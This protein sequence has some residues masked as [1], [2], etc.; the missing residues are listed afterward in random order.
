MPHATVALSV[1][2]AVSRFGG[3]R[4]LVLGDLMLDRYLRGKAER[5]SP[6]APVPVVKVETE[7]L[8]LGGAANVATNLAALGDLP[9]LV[10]LIGVDANAALLRSELARSNFD[11]SG[12]VETD[13]RPTSIKTRV[14]AGTQQVV[15]VDR[16][17]DTE[18]TG[19]LAR[20]ILES[21]EARID[22]AEAVVISDYGK[23]TLS[24]PVVDRAVHLARAR[25]LFV[26]VDPKETHFHRYRDVSILTPNHH[27][28][29]FAAGRKVKDDAGL[30][31]IGRQLREGLSAEYLLITRG[32][33]GMTLFS[34][35]GEPLHIPT[36]AQHVYD[37]TGAGD[38]VIATLTAAVAGGI[39]VPDACRLA[40][41]AA[42]RAIAEVGTYAVTRDDLV[43]ELAALAVT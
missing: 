31:E 19:A 23:G 36:V 7:E 20:R 16:E 39:D 41:V 4:V 42:R 13:D 38:T 22:G 35:S 30:Y 26:A 8:K 2:D 17:D 12:L 21:F 25:G 14:I 1:P 37:V 10:G 28:A 5:I 33:Q 11:D 18:A 40:N 27:E 6:E 15:R 29:C 3:H 9:L 32:E 34:Q 24:A 43:S